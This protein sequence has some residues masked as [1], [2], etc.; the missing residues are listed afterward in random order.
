MNGE[1]APVHKSN[2]SGRRVNRKLAIIV[3]KKSCVNIGFSCRFCIQ[4]YHKPYIIEMLYSLLLASFG[5]RVIRNNSPI[6]G[7]R[8]DMICI[9]NP[10][11]SN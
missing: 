5:S 7:L 2:T 4:I 10:G 6:N 9:Q 3:S 8:V 11:G 1:C